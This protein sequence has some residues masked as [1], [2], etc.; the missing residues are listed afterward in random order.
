MSSGACYVTF[1]NNNDTNNIKKIKL[2]T[3]DHYFVPVEAWHQIINAFDEPVHI[4][5]IQY[6]DECIE[7]DIERIGKL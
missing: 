7:E 5:E 3:F 1:A 2:N 6:G 4:I